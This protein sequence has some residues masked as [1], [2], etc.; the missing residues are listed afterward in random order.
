MLYC[1]LIAKFCI[2]RKAADVV[3]GVSCVVVD[4]ANNVSRSQTKI[5]GLVMSIP[6]QAT[7]I[8]R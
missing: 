2:D 6:G 1:V 7:S 8:A 5:A 4:V 3:V